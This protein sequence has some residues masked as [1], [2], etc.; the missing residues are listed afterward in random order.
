[1]KAYEY[2]NKIANIY[3]QMYE[4]K[5]WIALRKAVKFYIRNTL[6]GIRGKVLDIG[7]G[8]GYWIEFFLKE[9]FQVFALEPSENILNVAREKYKDKVVYFCSTIEEFEFNEKFEVLN[10]QGDVLSYV[11]DLDIVM[12]KLKKMIKPGGYLFATVDSYYYMKHLVKRY[13]SLEEYKIFE[14]THVTTVGSQYGVFKSH[15]F[16]IEDI[17]SL[18]RYGFKV[19]E[20]RGCGNSDDFETEVK[21]SNFVENSEHIYFSMLKL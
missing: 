8:T 1:M 17:Y 11:D 2:Y 19:L 9:G 12:N 13:G 21:N 10:L 15:C 7:T 16:T 18:E 5:R 4:D 20:I 14:K 3:D 6:Q